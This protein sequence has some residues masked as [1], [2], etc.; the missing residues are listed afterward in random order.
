[1]E[2]KGRAKKEIVFENSSGESS[3]ESKK[4]VNAN[5]SKNR[6]RNTATS[7]INFYFPAGTLN[8]MATKIH[9]LHRPIDKY[10]DSKK[11]SIEEDTSGL[12]NV[13]KQIHK[14]YKRILVDQIGVKE[15]EED[16]DKQKLALKLREIGRLTELIKL[17]IK[18]VKICTLCKRKFAGAEHLRTHETYS[19]VHAA[20]LLLNPSH[21]S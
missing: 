13:N 15:S 14:E 4:A 2:K 8:N 11:E 16:L 1:M 21:L 6:G 17:E 5:I 19:K 18:K 10:L 7:G 12:Y 9:H 3:P 20:N